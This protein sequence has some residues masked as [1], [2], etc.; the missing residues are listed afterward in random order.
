MTLDQP[1]R[2]MRVGAR[3]D[4][5]RASLDNAGCD[6]ALITSL[7]NIRYLTG[8]TGSAG[9]LFVSAERTLLTTDG[10]YKFQSAEQLGAC[11]VTADI[12]I[13]SPIVQQDALKAASSTTTRLGLE[14]GHVTWAQQR[15]MASDWLSVNELVA[16]SNLVENL[17]I[18]KDEGELDRMRRAA[19]IADEAL[20]RTRTLLSSGISEKEFAVALDFEIRRLGAEGN[21]FESIVASGPNGAKPHARPSDRQVRPGELIVLDFGALVEGYCSDMT[22]T[23]AVGELSDTAQRMFDVVIASQQ[24]GVDV[25]R[26]GVAAG[27]VHQVCLDVIAQAGWADAFLHSTGHGV[28]LDI[29][30][31]PWVAPKQSAELAVGNVVTVEP[32]VYLPDH[33]GV[34]IEDTLVVTNSGYE[35]LTCAPKTIAA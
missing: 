12:E 35:R 30:E 27:D 14:A 21:S 29:H 18:T 1:L 9:M 16:T 5:L 13:G 7:T 31:R 15:S 3:L 10:R 17:R 20:A 4:N 32:G 33:G 2:A 24:A 34:R 19:G 8:F 6:G 28:G 25:L 22:R 26:P 23:L 11:G